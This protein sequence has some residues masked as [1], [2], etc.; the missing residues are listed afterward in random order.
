METLAREYAIL[1]G[2]LF[3]YASVCFVLSILKERNDIADI[4][5]GL[6]F[7]VVSVT[8]FLR[9]GFA[10]DRG[11]LVTILVIIWALRLSTHIY[12]RN[13]GK[14]EDYRYR[15]WRESWGRYF[16][17]RSF[18]QIFILQGILALV[19]VS[20]VVIINVYRGGDL[21]FLDY[22]GLAIWFLGF[23]IEALGDLQLLR[24]MK[25][26]ENK[27]KLMRSGLWRYSRHPNYF[28]EV[29][30]WW[31][32]W[33]LSL[34]VVYGWFGIIGPIVITILITKVSGIPLLEQRWSSHPDFEDYK[35][36]TSVFFL[37][38]PKKVL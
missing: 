14:K 29:T 30:Q 17:L 20:P 15:Q 28:G 11:L 33:L 32:I 18:L 5:W 13:V 25:T 7:I 37:L 2:Y 21:T 10:F 35:R 34:S 8:S 4:A 1:A 6:A 38:P 27:G 12:F 16:Y 19:V 23:I 31:G 22:L 24:F 3:I 36:K 26:P 9:H